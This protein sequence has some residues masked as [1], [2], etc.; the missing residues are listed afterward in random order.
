MKTSISREIQMRS[1]RSDCGTTPDSHL[2]LV[3]SRAV[4]TVVPSELEWLLDQIRTKEK[5]D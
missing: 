3:Y 2:R 5:A 1:R 4:E